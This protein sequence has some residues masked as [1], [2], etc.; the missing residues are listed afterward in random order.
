[1]KRTYT[2]AII[3]FIM[4]AL[5]LVLGIFTF[6]HL[7]TTL[8]AFVYVYGI[9]SI[10]FG[11]VEIVM[12]VLLTK[13]FD[14]APISPLILGVLNILMG[15]LLVS[16][17]WVGLMALSILFPFWLIFLCVSRLCSLNLIRR[18]AGGVAFWFSAIVN[19]LGLVAGFLLL[20]IPTVS[21]V[22]MG[23]MIGVYLILAAAEMF[24]FGVRS[25]QWSKR[26]GA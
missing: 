22:A 13:R 7:D 12:F 16:N 3:Q 10:L 19:V 14:W 2:Y 11:I 4:G 24:V 18:L 25:I 5:L 1:M 9:A 17:V 20:F 8:T 15:I 21:M 26:I 23:Y 6:F